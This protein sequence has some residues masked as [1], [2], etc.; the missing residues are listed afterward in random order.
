MAVGP[1]K[2]CRYHWVVITCTLLVVSPR[3]HSAETAAYDY[4]NQVRQQAGMSAFITNNELAVA[5]RNHARYMHVHHYGGHGEQSG[6]QGFTGRTHS[7]RALRAGYSSSQTGENVS[8][9]T[10]NKG[11]IESIDG[12]M[13]AIYHRFAFLSFRYDEV[14]I[15]SVQSDAYSTHAYNFGNRRKRLLCQ[16][17]NEQLQGRYYYDVCADPRARIPVQDMQRAEHEVNR[18]SADIVV[19]PGDQSKDIPPAFYKEDPDPLPG[20]D[21][22]GYPISIQFNP[23]VYTAALPVVTRFQLFRAEGDTPV[24]AIVMLDSQNDPNRKFEANEHALFPRYRLAWGTDYRVEVDY[25]VGGKSQQ[26]SWQFRTREMNLPMFTVSDDSRDVLVKRG[27]KFAIYVPPRGPRDG[28]AEY[29][30][31]FPRG[32]QLDIEMYDPHTLLVKASGIPG[33]A[34]ISFHGM[35]ISLLVQVD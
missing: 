12:L 2:A 29:R 9:H 8:F 4:L 1:H 26:H 3:L 31:R 30:T 19:W 28:Q 7:E 33:R 23:T 18:Q 27:E 34:S 14:G 11:Y 24:D 32:M 5:A 16:Q 35:D 21:V 22:S 25:L 13:A 10:G 15:G 20:H 6:R 17:A